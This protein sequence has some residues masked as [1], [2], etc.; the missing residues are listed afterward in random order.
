MLS[1]ISKRPFP[2]H[3]G[4]YKTRSINCNML[5]NKRKINKD[6]KYYWDYQSVKDAFDV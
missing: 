5:A 6:G 3:L 4:D 2:D 1:R